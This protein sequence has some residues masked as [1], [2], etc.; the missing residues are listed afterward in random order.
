MKLSYW[1]IRLLS[2]KDAFVIR[3]NA[4]LRRRPHRS[5]KRTLR[6][7]Y[8]RS[9]R[10]QGYWG[11]TAYVWQ[12]LWKH[13][14]TFGLLVVFYAAFSIILGA[15]ANQDTYQQIS[16]LL[17][18]SA[19]EVIKGAWGSAGQAAVLLVSTFITP[20]SMTPE[21]QIY[22]TLSSIF[23]WMVTVW[24]LRDLMKGNK[25][26]LRD[27]LYSAG[28]P[29]FASI[30]VVLVGIIQLI[31]VALAALA[32]TALF[33]Y[34]VLDEG[35]GLMIYWVF[36]ALVAILV[37]Y[38]MVPTFLS[39]VIVT[40]PGMYPFR[41][42]RAAGDLVVGRRLRILYRIVWLAFT[43]VLGWAAVMI[44]AVLLDTGIKNIWSAIKGV[45]IVPV[46]A[47]IMVS[48]TLVWLSAYI[49]MLYRKIVDDDTSP[50]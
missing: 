38:W 25:P 14:R 27:G 30:I 42:L 22:V 21:Q 34:G 48:A 8:R 39:L 33:S 7:D 41:A 17:N 50:A 15:I 40:L 35:V 24:L 37:L 23:V 29:F 28:S 16:D 49:Y 5:F 19:G 2:W 26:K 9:L 12:Y 3:K 36:A 44:P 47:A 6:R 10:L 46:L 45:P 18:K 4:F 1:G 20:S 31:P 13:R 43:V 11:F 32:Y